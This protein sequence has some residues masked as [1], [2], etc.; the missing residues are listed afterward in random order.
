MVLKT[1]QPNNL[2]ASSLNFSPLLFVFTLVSYSVVPCFS[3]DFSFC[4]C[5]YISCLYLVLLYYLSC[6]SSVDIVSIVSI[7]NNVSIV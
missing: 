5:I 2:F 1:T 3:L 6:V 7:V 4:I